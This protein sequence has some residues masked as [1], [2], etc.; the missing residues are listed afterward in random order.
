MKKNID[1]CDQAQHSERMKNVLLF[2]VLCFLGF[3]SFGFSAPPN[4]LFIQTDDQ[5]PWALGLVEPMADTPNMDRLFR[6]GAWLKNSYVTTPVCTPSRISTMTGRYSS[7]FG[8][9]DWL[10]PRK[11]TER[12]LDPK[13]P[14]W[15]QRLKAA[16]YHTGLIGKW[17]L[18]LPDA[19]HPTVF[20]FDYFMGHRHG[21]WP[22]NKPTLEKDGEQVKYDAMTVE[23]LRD[24]VVAFLRRNKEKPFCLAWHT[25]APHTAWLPVADEDWAP[26]EDLDIVFPHPDYP[27]LDKPRLIKMTRQYLASVRSVDSNLG[28]VLKE[29]DELGLR[30]NTIV[31]FTSDHGYNMGHNG[32]WHKGNGHW[33][34]QP[35]PNAQPNIPKGQRPNMYDN[36]IKVPTAIRW[37]GQIKPGTVI[38][39]PVSNLDWFPTLCA[40]G[41]TKAKASTTQR[42]RNLLPVL[43][44]AATADWPNEVYA[45]Y[46]TI[47]QSQTHMRMIRT[48][49]WKLVRDFLNPQRDELFSLTDDPGETTNLLAEADPV[50]LKTL[51]A[52]IRAQMSAIKDPLLKTL[53][54][55]AK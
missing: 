39:A 6:E 14:V 54:D 19:H 11:E 45:E 2:V 18:G 23:V 33:V 16:G 32:I 30:D 8:I 9:T 40:M 34:T 20:G 44:G 49:E 38:D 31:I 15:P 47:H 28:I 43:T 48:A 36:A 46:S 21:G 7:E 22:N 12:G 13:A 53:T 50:L 42:G 24:E 37:P 10:N 29:L 26:F 51:D 4:I 52:K 3:T 25:R 55:A 17:H 1:P 5:A 35:A 41:G 27:N